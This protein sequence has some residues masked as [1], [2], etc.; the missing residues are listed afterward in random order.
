MDERSQSVTNV[1][2]VSFLPSLSPKVLKVGFVKGQIA[3]SGITRDLLINM[4]R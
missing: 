2:S 4:H 1:Y 3:N